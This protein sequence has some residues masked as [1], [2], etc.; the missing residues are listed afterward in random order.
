[1]KFLKGN[2]YISNDCIFEASC[3]STVV[4]VL[5][6]Q[7]IGP[8]LISGWWFADREWDDNA[9]KALLREPP[10]RTCKKNLPVLNDRITFRSIDLLI[11]VFS[12]FIKKSLMW[13]HRDQ[14]WA[15]IL[16]FCFFNFSF[17]LIFKKLSFRLIV[18]YTV[19]LSSV[20]VWLW[21]HFWWTQTRLWN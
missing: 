3:H 6:S 5:G 19:S 21:A 7:P 10:C 17:I 4:S 2:A 13:V 9:L 20:L 18:V 14:K 11:N 12:F 16:F 8:G 15:F 1:M